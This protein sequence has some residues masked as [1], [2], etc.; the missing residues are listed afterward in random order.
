MKR[1]IFFFLCLIRF[2]ANAS[3]PVEVGLYNTEV[4]SVGF[5]TN[6]PHRSA[7]K[8][9]DFTPIADVV[10]KIG[11]TP[12]I[13][14]SFFPWTLQDGSYQDFPVEFCE[15]VEQFDAIPLITWPP[16]QADNAN[17]VE[18]RNR[19]R[20]Q[21]DFNCVSIASGK[22]DAYIKRWAQGAKEYGKVVYVRYMHEFIAAPYPT[23]FM[24]DS[25]GNSPVNYIKAFRRITDIF[26]QAGATNVINIWCVGESNG[27]PG[28][29]AFFPGDEYVD[30]LGI[31]AYNRPPNYTAPFENIFKGPY[32]R[33][34]A[35]S[36]RP[37]MICEVAAVEAPEDEN[38]KVNW[39]NNMM[40]KGIPEKMPRIRAVVFFNSPGNPTK[41]YTY[42][43][44]SSPQ[45][46]KAIQAIFA[47]PKFRATLPAKRL[48]DY[49]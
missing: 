33:M 47:D 42:K 1:I 23:S 41:G 39:L 46:F 18:D 14:N 24:L 36:K 12:M 30:W 2:Q 17:Q 7:T 15:Y 37:I 20:P 19:T 31:D 28:M 4:L 8:P 35:M 26:R 22:H 43:F 11:S 3:E 5:L 25:T 6:F 27:G 21:S 44:D 13:I 49:L 34:V 32:N 16:G 38:A 40:Y 29:A 45:S 48:P 9:A 10:K